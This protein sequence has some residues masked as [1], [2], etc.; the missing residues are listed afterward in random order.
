MNLQSAIAAINKHGMLLTFP[1]KNAKLPLS[2][3]SVAYPR[4]KMKWEWD[5][6]GDNRVVQLWHLRERLSRSGKVVYT[7]WYKGRATFFSR[8][9]FTKRL[10]ASLA[11]TNRAAHM[12]TR[13]ARDILEALEENS[14]LS[15]KV[16]KKTVDLRGKFHEATYNRAMKELWSRYLIVGYGEVDEGAFPSLAIGATKLLFEDL[17]KEALQ[18]I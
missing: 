3:W 6:D 15:T 7:K 16:L 11:N 10:A 2:L 17:Y 18:H 1:I 13:E 8:K 12:L 14:P 4:T 5:D 9:E